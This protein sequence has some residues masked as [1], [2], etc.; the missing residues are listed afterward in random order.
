M[1]PIYIV[2]QQIFSVKE[3]RFK[4][5]IFYNVQFSLVN[6]IDTTPPYWTGH[7]MPQIIPTK[8]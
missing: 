1:I 5:N 3:I 7:P 4:I 2:S 8:D 6:E